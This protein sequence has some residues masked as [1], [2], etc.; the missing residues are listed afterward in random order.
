MP[1]RLLLLTV[2]HAEE[3]VCHLALTTRQVTTPRL[4]GSHHLSGNITSPMLPSTA[5]GWGIPSPSTQ[6]EPQVLSY[7]CS[8]TESRPPQ[9]FYYKS[10]K[11]TYRNIKVHI[12]LCFEDKA[13]A[14][15]CRSNTEVLV[16]REQVGASHMDSHLQERRDV[17]KP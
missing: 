5:T 1:L 14:A 4:H 10:K 8:P 6:R 15:A 17:F 9:A 7:P 11:A 16:S 13:G 3:P 12:F 2:F